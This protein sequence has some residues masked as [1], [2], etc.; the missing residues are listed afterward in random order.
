M[1]VRE[2][3]AAVRELVQIGARFDRAGDGELSLTREGGHHRD[4]IAHAGG[5]ATGAEIQRA[6]VTRTLDAS[7]DLGDRA[8]ARP[9]PV[10]RRQRR[11]RR[12]HPARAR[13]GAARRR[14]GGAGPRGRARHRRHRPGLRV[15]DQPERLDR[16][17]G[18]RGPARRR[19]R[20][21][22]RVRPVPPDR[23][24]ARPELARPAAARQRGG[25]R[26]GRVPRRRR[27][28]AVHDRPARARRPRAA[29]HRR[30][31]DPAP[32]ARDRRRA[33]VARRPALRRGEVAGALPDH[34]RD[35]ALA[36]HRPGARADPGRPGLPLR[37]RRR[38]HRPA[39]RV[40]AAA[41]CSSAARPPAPACTARTGWRPTRCSKGWCSAGA[42]PRRSSTRLGEPAPP[43]AALA[44]A[45]PAGA[46][47]AVDARPELQQLMSR[48]VGVLRDRDRAERGRRRAREARRGGR[49]RAGHRGVGDDQPAHR[50]VR[51]RAG[52]AAARG[53]PRRALARR[54]PGPRRRALARAPRHRP[55]PGRHAGH[56]PTEDDRREHA[57]YPTSPT[58]SPARWPRTSARPA[59][60]PPSRPSPAD[61]VADANL[62]ARADGVRGR[63]AGR[64]VRVRRGR[65]G[66][67]S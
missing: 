36:R 47:L 17:R 33:H 15:D 13:R 54:L 44:D 19:G 8:R 43:P 28:R 40:V 56:R 63:A 41:G 66:P 3:P 16:R 67:A 32:D 61:A 14:R 30:Q 58:S 26:R 6:L 46:L 38:A 55:R 65:P 37:E 12:A 24:L 59:T 42:S 23:H 60:S 1:L 11:R 4:R 50:R 57:D 53:D 5:D 35:V 34:P 21:R 48:D 20:P 39:R 51:A 49:R 45:P 9:G 7:G 52:R 27:G 18:R 31:G 22:P 25:A 2:G 10:A 29:R 62:V 64:G